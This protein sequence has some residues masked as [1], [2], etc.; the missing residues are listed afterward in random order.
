MGIVRVQKGGQNKILRPDQ[1]TAL[2]QYTVSHAINGGKG[3][4]K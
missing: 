1:H 3:A 4:T 2:I